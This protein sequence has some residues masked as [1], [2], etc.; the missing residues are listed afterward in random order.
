M[1]TVES[2]SFTAMLKCTDTTM[3][4]EVNYSQD[5]QFCCQHIIGIEVVWSKIYRILII[6]IS[7][8]YNWL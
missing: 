3:G 6:V 8:I 1:C 4:N 7:T 2:Y 5:H